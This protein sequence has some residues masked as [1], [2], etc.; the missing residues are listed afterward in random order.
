MAARQNLYDLDV[1]QITEWLASINLDKV[2]G[3]KF[4]EMQID[5]ELLADGAWP[6]KGA[7]CVS[8]VSPK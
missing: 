4:V 6:C 5:G 2:L 7:V 3:K 8:K 1:K